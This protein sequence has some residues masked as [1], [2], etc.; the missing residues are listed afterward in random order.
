ML[1]ILFLF[2]S[3]FSIS[4]GNSY[5]VWFYA[6]KVFRNLYMS[7]S[8]LW[9]SLKMLIRTHHKENLLFLI[10]KCFPFNVT[11]QIS[12]IS[13]I[14]L[15]LNKQGD[16][17]QPWRTPSPV[18]NQS[19]CCFMSS[20]NCCFLICIRF[21]RRQVRWS[22]IPISLRIF[23]FF[24]IHTVKGFGIINKQEGDVFLKFSCIFDDP[25]D[26]CN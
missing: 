4:S 7:V 18:W 1:L 19:V 5:P 25:M 9:I 14:S 8:F 15:Q 6:L 12:L 13:L 21:L 2:E 26:V 10:W 23:Q 24:V 11:Y 22:G 3:S 20:S 17:I 16:N